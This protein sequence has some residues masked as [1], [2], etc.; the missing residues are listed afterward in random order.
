MNPD[1]IEVYTEPNGNVTIHVYGLKRFTVEHTPQGFECALWSD[2]G[3]EFWITTLDE[4][5]A[6]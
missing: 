2:G 5:V 1:S 6:V 4:E 3:P